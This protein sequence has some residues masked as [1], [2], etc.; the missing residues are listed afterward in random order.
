[1]KPSLKR[2]VRGRGKGIRG[3]LLALI[4]TLLGT[5]LVQFGRISSRE[6]ATLEGGE[7][8]VTEPGPETR[9][10]PGYAHVVPAEASEE[11]KEKERDFSSGGF[12]DDEATLSGNRKASSDLLC[13]LTSIDRLNW[14][15]SRS[16]EV[17]DGVKD[18]EGAK[19]EHQQ[20]E[21]AEEGVVSAVLV[22]AYSRPS[23]L[24][25]TLTAL[26]KRLRARSVSSKF[27][28]YVSQDR[29]TDPLNRRG[30]QVGDVIRSFDSF[31]AGHLNH[32]EDSENRDVDLAAANIRLEMINYYHLS[33]HYKWALSQIFDCLGYQKV[34]VIEDDMEVSVDFFSL[35]EAGARLLDQDPTI[36]SISS[37]NDLGYQEYVEDPRAMYRTDFF[38]GLGWMMSKVLWN[39][40]SVKWP[41]AFWDDWMRDDQ[42]RRGRSTIYPEISRNINFGERG[43][44]RGEE[45]SK[46]VSRVVGNDVYVNF[47]EMNS[48]GLLY[49][50][51]RSKLYNRVKATIPI[52][53]F[54]DFVFE[55]MASDSRIE[56]STEEEL[57]DMLKYL[58]LP[59]PRVVPRN[60]FEGIVQLRN[61]RFMLYLVPA[62]K[63]F[64]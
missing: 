52:V 36:Y 43:T 15:A 38:P 5:S 33:S 61:G 48:S 54:E 42:Q 31:L 64:Y 51:Y 39:E 22:I 7:E 9:N 49:H 35:M 6:S 24:K 63:D 11:K 47:V 25:R 44:S 41:K 45:Y 53:S 28:V 21:R 19:G 57:A 16:S 30:N 13:S 23:Y 4:L 56:Y 59:P 40:L 37:W 46:Y 12:G 8:P 14:S 34:I 32:E 1:M 62:W 18:K 17:I 27:P 58:D 50:E 20:P 29:K 2:R 60:S 3:V 55:A 26:K 10:Y